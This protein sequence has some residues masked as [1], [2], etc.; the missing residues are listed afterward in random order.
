MKNIILII[1][2]LVLI[3]CEKNRNHSQ[4]TVENLAS[5][6]VEVTKEPVQETPK[7]KE[8]GEIC[9]LYD[10]ETRAQYRIFL[11][12]NK[13]LYLINRLNEEET[14]AY[15]GL[16]TTYLDL[17]SIYKSS[18]GELRVNSVQ[19][20]LEFNE[21]GVLR[22]YVEILKAYESEDNYTKFTLV[23]LRQFRGK[24]D[25]W[26]NSYPQP[27]TISS[28]HPEELEIQNKQLPKRFRY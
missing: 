17:Y 18:N 4:G 3:S 27:L 2:A 6:T 23:R 25:N 13:D 1:T 22:E 24:D 20:N 15:Y 21:N 19:G 26:I 16:R 9:N 12:G 11:V 10:E 5:P 14:I 8:K 28:C 7:V